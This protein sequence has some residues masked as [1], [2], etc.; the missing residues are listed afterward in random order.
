MDSSIFKGYF[1]YFEYSN[2]INSSNY[3]PNYFLG[4]SLNFANRTVHFK[5]FKEDN[6]NSRNFGL[7]EHFRNLKIT[8]DIDKLTISTKEDSRHFRTK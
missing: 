8:S 4:D 5:D 3:R 6:Y 2:F 7:R 1:K